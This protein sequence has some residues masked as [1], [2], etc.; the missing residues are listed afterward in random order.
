M[1]LLAT[2]TFNHLFLSYVLLASLCC[3][4]FILS[5]CVLL[6]KRQRKAGLTET[7]NQW[8]WLWMNR[9]VR[10]KRWKVISKRKPAPC[11]WISCSRSSLTWIFLKIFLCCFLSK[12]LAKVETCSRKHF[13]VFISF[14][15]MINTHT[16]S[17]FNC[18]WKC[19]SSL[20]CSHIH[21]NQKHFHVAFQQGY[22]FSVSP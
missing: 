3:A 17:L 22:P 8:N 4:C 20:C 19:R 6:R 13:G 11:I 1:F 15:S 5:T 16:L 12:F 10:R 7:Q 18:I 21:C 14:L 2:G 9:I